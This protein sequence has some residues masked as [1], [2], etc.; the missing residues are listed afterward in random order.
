MSTEVRTPDGRSGGA[1]VRRGTGQAGPGGA[2]QVSDSRQ[3]PR[4]ARQRRPGRPLHPDRP[5]SPVRPPGPGRP[6]RPPRTGGPGRSAR[7]LRQDPQLRQVR[8]P[9]GGGTGPRGNVGPPRSRITAGSVRRHGRSSF[10]LLLGLLLGGGLICLL[11]VQTTFAA[12]SIRISRLEQQNATQS[13]QVQ[14]LQQQ[15]TVQQTASVLQREAVRLGMRP[16]QTLSFVD[17]RTH[18]IVTGS[19]AAVDLPGPH[20]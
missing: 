13:Q 17:V 18:K 16:A 11:V 20:R 3:P 8:P 1:Q 10:V 7:D 9:L 19:P 6:G 5:A 14:E 4:P 2:Q 12:A 15:V